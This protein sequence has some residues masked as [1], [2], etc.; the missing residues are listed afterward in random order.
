MANIELRD[1]FAGQAI[2][3]AIGRLYQGLAGKR[4]G[5]QLAAELAVAAYAVAAAMLAERANGQPAPPDDNFENPHTSGLPGG[6][7]G[8]WP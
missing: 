8:G 6:T 4:Q 5:T 2:A 7:G 1:Y 3:G